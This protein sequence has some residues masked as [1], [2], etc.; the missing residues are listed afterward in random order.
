MSGV[1][2]EAVFTGLLSKLPRKS[3]IL[4]SDDNSAFNL[5][6]YSGYGVVIDFR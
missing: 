4:E 2:I 5:L 1:G 3:K 6:T